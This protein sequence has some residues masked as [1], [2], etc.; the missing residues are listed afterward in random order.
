MIDLSPYPEILD[1]DFN[2][3]PN[4]YEYYSLGKDLQNAFLEAGNC[5]PSSF[6]DYKVPLRIDHIFRSKSIISLNYK[7]DNSVQLSDHYLVIAEFLLN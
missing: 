7:V 3:V 6:H 1:G 4:S 2:S 5:S